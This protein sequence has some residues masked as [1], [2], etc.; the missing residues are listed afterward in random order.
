M[1]DGVLNAEGD[2]VAMHRELVKAA[3]VAG[4]PVGE[5]LIVEIL[6]DEEAHRSEFRGF[7]E[8]YRSE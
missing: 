6:A 2:A 1:I 7:A 4:D 3:E 8:E 5:D